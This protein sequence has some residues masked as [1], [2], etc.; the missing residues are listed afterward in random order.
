[1]EERLMIKNLLFGIRDPGDAGLKGSSILSGFVVEHKYR[2]S[3][4]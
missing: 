3:S 1:M 4:E 2:V